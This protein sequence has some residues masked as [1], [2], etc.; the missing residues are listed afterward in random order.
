M[1]KPV[2]ILDSFKKGKP[3]EEIAAAR[4]AKAGWQIEDVRTDKEYQAVDID[5][6]CSKDDDT[7][8]VDIKT[9]RCYYTGNYF[10]ETLAN[11][12]SNKAGWAYTSMADYILIVYDTPAGH[13]LHV[14]DMSLARAWIHQNEWKCKKIENATRR[15]NG[16]IYHSQGIICNRTKFAE[17]SNAVIQILKIEEKEV[18]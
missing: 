18:A 10:F 8:T 2:Y 13:E 15:E 9:D 16:S 11:I 14:I 1:T 17:E 6:V 3:A 12:E 4:I 5:Y 7:W